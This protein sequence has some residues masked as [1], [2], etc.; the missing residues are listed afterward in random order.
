MTGICRKLIAAIAVAFVI[1]C[2]GEDSQQSVEC[3][4]GTELDEELGEC[5]LVVPECADDEVLVEEFNE[6]V[7]PD[8]SYCAEGTELD[9]ET[10]MCVSSIDVECGEQTVEDRGVCLPDGIACGEKTVVHNGECVPAEEVCAEG[11]EN[12]SGDDGRVD[13]RPAEGVCGEGT[14]FDVARRQCVPASDIAC[15]AGTTELDGFCRPAQ[16][17]YEDLAADP[18][19]DFDDPE[20]SGDL[21]AVSTGD[22]T[23]FVGTVGEPEVAD[24]D[25]IQ[26][27][28]TLRFETSAGQWMR[29]KV[30]SLGLP[31]PGFFVDEL[32]GDYHR[33]ADDH[34]GLE[35]RRDVLIPEAG[36]YEIEIS[37]LP[38]LVGDSAPAGGEDW[39]YVGVVE[40]MDAP[41][42]RQINPFE[43]PLSGDVT[44]LRGGV[45]SI[46]ELDDVDSIQF[47][48]D[49][50]PEDAQT[51][52]QVWSSETNRAS[53]RELDDSV[54]AVSSPGDS[55]LLVV[56]RVY[57]RGD[58]TAYSATGRRA[59]T[60]PSGESISKQVDLQAGQSL[61]VFQ[62]NTENR[63][64]TASIIEGGQLHAEASHMVSAGADAG[65]NAVYWYAEEATTANV[66]LENN[67]PS[68][69]ESIAVD[70]RVR[71]AETVDVETGDAQSI[72]YAGSMDRSERHYYRVAVDFDDV[73]GI[74]ATPADGQLLL[75][76]SDASGSQ[77]AQ[78]PDSIFFDATPQTYLMYVEAM[79][80]LQDGYTLLL[81]EREIT[82]VDIT[83]EP[84]ADIGS[85]V[86][87]DIEVDQCSNINDIEVDL[88][89]YHTWPYD[90]FV[91]LQAPNGQT[92]VLHNYEG[93]FGS[94]DIIASYPFPEDGSLNTGEQLLDFIDMIGMGEWELT[95]EDFANIDTGTLASW[96]LYLVC[97]D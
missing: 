70:L 55:M 52:L 62:Y 79:E 75:S 60:L 93:A 7:R 54:V 12:A 61:G 45:F 1:G 13:C 8:E 82:V 5:V 18:D 32:D 34:T 28:D 81:D 92:A 50:V 53:T 83:S 69:I 40:A 64:V 31:Q 80:A 42:P 39:N 73:L 48:F 10:L 77:V 4:D 44:N 67:A 21:G 27:V 91:E 41:E 97:E 15:G 87:D 85:E 63:G 94:E 11:T 88:E 19:V 96:R 25:Q 37:N 74:D 51:E 9:D 30:Y 58:S 72:G 90:L 78:Q 35:A 23:V 33:R 95:V 86:T 66:L 49:D 29:L 22:R 3:A 6:C 17:Y 65:T 2:G 20:Q 59:Q 84:Q 16:P 43:M 47:S 24:G 36:S 38:Q 26:D 46:D 56:D 76:A 89:I 57:A 71:S 68:D 14:A